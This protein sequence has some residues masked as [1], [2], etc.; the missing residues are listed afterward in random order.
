MY[1]KE[2]KKNLNEAKHKQASNLTQ[3]QLKELQKQADQYYKQYI[4]DLKKI[5][6]QRTLTNQ[7]QMKQ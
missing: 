5:E 2:R 1:D 4:A 3:K 6:E 7:K